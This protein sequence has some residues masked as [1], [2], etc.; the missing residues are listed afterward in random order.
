M[1]LGLGQLELQNPSL[2]RLGTH[3]V[4]H[5]VETLGAPRHNFEGIATR[6]PCAG[7]TTG[8]E[9]LVCEAANEEGLIVEFVSE[10]ALAVQHLEGNLALSAF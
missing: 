6:V 1:P 10:Q 5:T 3:G 7:G 8:D 4:Q 2:Q 9:L